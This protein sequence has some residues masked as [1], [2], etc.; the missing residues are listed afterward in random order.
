MYRGLAVIA[1]LAASPLTAHAIVMG[2][3]VTSGNG[4]FIELTL[5]FNPPNGAQNTVGED[6]FQNNNL[7]AFN[8]GQNLE[9]KSDPLSVN[10]T[11][12]GVSSLN[13][14]TI[15]ASHYVFFDPGPSTSQQGF[16]DFDADILGVI[17]STDL[18]EDSDFLL[19]NNVNY[20]NPTLRGLEPGDSVSIDTNNAKRLLVDWVASSPGD[21]VRVLTGESA[22]GEDP[23]S[24]NPPGVGGC[25]PSNDVPE[26]PLLML[27]AAG[28][29]GLR[30]THR[31]RKS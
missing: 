28:L 30:L 6:T 31:K 23:C 20:L 16:V 17:T 15:V 2:G 10:I 11:P 8:E 25:P 27:M 1:L 29:L 18:L 26:P 22:G 24:F 4:S 13:V 21:F 9:I 14:G 12:S 19:N 3:N 7:Y 5:P